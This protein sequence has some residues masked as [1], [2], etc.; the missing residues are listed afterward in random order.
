MKIAHTLGLNARPIGGHTKTQ[1]ES[2][3][4]AP[5]GLHLCE[6]N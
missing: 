3:L 1:K 4:E 5:F 6:K 2:T